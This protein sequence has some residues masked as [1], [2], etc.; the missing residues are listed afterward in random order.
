MTMWPEPRDGQQP[1][2]DDFDALGEVVK[3]ADRML[4]ADDRDYVWT[5]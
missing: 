1:E 4:G 3:D 2:P 5:A